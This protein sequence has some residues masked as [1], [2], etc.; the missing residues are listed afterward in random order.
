M[1][2]NSCGGCL[3]T[4]IISSAHILSSSSSFFSSS[5]SFCFDVLP[6]SSFSIVNT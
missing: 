6:F 5:S 4:S 2:C 3:G 1:F